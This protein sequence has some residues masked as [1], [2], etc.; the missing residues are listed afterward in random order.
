MNNSK[1][2]VSLAQARG[3][4]AAIVRDVERGS[5]VEL[6]RRGTPVVVLISVRD[7]ERLTGGSASFERAFGEFARE[8]DLKAL[9]IDP[10]LFEGIRDRSPGREVRF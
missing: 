4:L 2:K 1:K 7:Y 3:R 5:S 9:K 6:T 8:V 10:G